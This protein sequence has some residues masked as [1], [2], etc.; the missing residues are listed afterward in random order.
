VILR[1]LA[2]LVT[3]KIPQETTV[4]ST[5]KNPSGSY[6]CSQERKFPLDTTV[7]PNSKEGMWRYVS[8]DSVPGD[9]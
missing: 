9:F 8:N 4:V 6:R 5:G 3:R 1:V 7:V 2:G